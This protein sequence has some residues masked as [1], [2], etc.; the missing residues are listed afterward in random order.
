M[1]N[2]HHWD[3]ETKISKSIILAE[4]DE[5]VKEETRGEGGNGIGQIRWY[6]NDICEDWAKAEEFLSAHENGWYDCLAVRYKE[7]PGVDFTESKKIVELRKREKQLSI[8]YIK[9]NSIVH[10][11]GVKSEYISCRTCGSKI[12]SRYFGDEYG[13]IKNICPVCKEDIRPQST[14]DRLSRMKE[15]LNSLSTKI[16]S[17]E[18]EFIKKEQSKMK[19]TIKWLV[20]FEYHT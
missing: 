11:K 14:L 9:H 7:F 18:D 8:E 5:F 2:I 1:H 13:Q 15:K 16:N 12:A 3:Y 17:M 19:P 20:K 4:I 6:D 10:Y